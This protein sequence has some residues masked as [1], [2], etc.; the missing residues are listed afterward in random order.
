M[1]DGIPDGY[2]SAIASDTAM[3]VRRRAVGQ[4]HDH[5]V[6]GVLV[7]GTESDG[8]D[9]DTEECVADA[10]REDLGTAPPVDRAV[11]EREAGR[12]EADGGDG[13]EALAVVP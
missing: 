13:T 2:D 5:E 4:H 3:S 10:G 6:P 12:G 7:D 1:R 11:G 8:G 9:G